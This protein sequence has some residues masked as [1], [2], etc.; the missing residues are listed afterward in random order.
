MTVS[1]NS[2]YFRNV[3]EIPVRDHVGSFAKGAVMDGAFLGV[4]SLS[5]RYGLV[6]RTGLIEEETDRLHTHDYDQI[7]WFVSSDP[8]DLLTLGAEVEFTIGEELIRMRFDTPTAL[9]IPKGTPHFSPVVDR[10]DKRFFF[11]AVSGAAAF[12]AEVADPDAER[13]GGPWGEFLNKYARFRKTLT[14]ARK[15]IYHYGSAMVSDSGGI[16]TYANA[17]PYGFSMT[18]SWETVTKAHKLGPRTPEMTY[19]AHMHPNYD[20]LL[21][22]LSMDPEHLDALPGQADFCFGTEEDREHAVVTKP[23]VMVNPAGT[24]HLPLQFDRVDR[25]MAFLTMSSNRTP[26]ENAPVAVSET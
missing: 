8:N 16:Y 11:V 6:D 19:R 3:R 15:G 13:D 5:I 1:E 4:D 23:S 17:A 12:R 9:F 26:M 2:K 20:E 7:L 21:I 25:P 18:M 22:F 10:L 24:F 14:F